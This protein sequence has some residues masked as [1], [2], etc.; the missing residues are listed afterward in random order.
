MSAHAALLLFGLQP[1]QTRAVT[2]DSLSAGPALV[3]NL[4]PPAHKALPMPQTT[5]SLRHK[6]LSRKSR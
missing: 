2:L 4:P 1:T 6:K 5:Y 3:L